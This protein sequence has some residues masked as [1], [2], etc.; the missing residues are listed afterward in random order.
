MF[1]IH[2]MDPLDKPNNTASDTTELALDT[3]VDQEVVQQTS[4]MKDKARAAIADILGVIH[5]FGPEAREFRR[6]IRSMEDCLDQRGYSEYRIGGVVPAQ[7]F[8]QNL[9]FLGERFSENLVYA[10]VNGEPDAILPPEGTM[11]TY[12][13]IRR[14][15]MERAKVF[16]SSNFTR[17]ENAEAVARGKTRNFHQIGLEIF[18]YPT[19]DAALEAI[20]A[21]V[22]M[23][24]A[25]G[26]Q[27]SIVRIADKR[28]IRGFMSRYP[29]EDQVILQSVMDKADDD[30]DRLIA[31]Y[32]EK[33]GKSDQV[34]QEMAEFI[35]LV[36]RPSLTIQE[37]ASYAN[38]SELYEQG[39]ADLHTL[40]EHLTRGQLMDVRLL[41]FMA[42]SWDACDSMMFDIRYPGYDSAIAGGGILTYPGYKPDSTKAGC[43]VGVTRVFEILRSSLQ[44][45]QAV[46]H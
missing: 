42:K 18:N 6:V 44:K 17:N 41:P 13:F 46:P 1:T 34:K 16:Y 29:A 30:S 25:A 26:L 40:E 36:Q 24:Q 5:Y 45:R 31:L 15:E 19:N 12:N 3:R 28:L 27:D 2:F 37:L 38:G 20:R 43:G 10:K 23:I 9:D 32:E 21:P 8:L 39:L 22:A 7:V 4:E 35:R 11:L 33:G 14:N